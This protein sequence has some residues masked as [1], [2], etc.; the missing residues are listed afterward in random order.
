MSEK[1]E[2]VVI[3]P[4]LWLPYWAMFRLRKRMAA[5]GYDAYV[6]R[7]HTV[8]STLEQSAKELN[9]FLKEIDA[10]TIHLVSQSL[11]GI[12]IRALFHY[13]PNQKP[14][15]IVNFVPPHKGSYTASY[16]SRFVVMRWLLGKSIAQLLRGLPNHW[17]T[18]DREIGV[19]AGDWPIGLGMFLRNLPTPNDGVVAVVE[20]MLPGLKEHRVVKVG[21]TPS[22]ISKTVAGYI[23]RFLVDGSFPEQATGQR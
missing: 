14:G 23:V 3:L 21:H 13:F 9:E 1:R 8:V 19:I 16:F 18:P 4:G 22:V 5:A 11:G 2:A 17:K 6:F 10:D 12:V 7:Y 20:T 15:R